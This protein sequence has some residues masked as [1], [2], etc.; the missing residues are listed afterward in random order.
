M[1]PISL[2]LN[3]RP[4]CNNYLIELNHM[5]KELQMFGDTLTLRFLWIQNIKIAAIS[6]FL[7]LC[8]IC[9][10]VITLNGQNRMHKE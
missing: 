4:N 3:L 10:H 8:Q 7:K 2:F 1:A 5:H 9:I 6:L